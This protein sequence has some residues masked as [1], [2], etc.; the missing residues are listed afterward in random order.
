MER[1][2]KQGGRIHEFNGAQKV[3]VPQT[4][5]DHRCGSALESS[6]QEDVLIRPIGSALGMRVCPEVR[7]RLLHAGRTPAGI[8]SIWPL[9]RGGHSQI[10]HWLREA[11]ATCLS[12]RPSSLA[13]TP[14]LWEDMQ[15][16]T[17]GQ[18]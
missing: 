12:G 16:T 2:L 18:N 8:P 6:A 10:G 9:G 5:G 7:L 13:R 11:A 14:K 4:L 17:P 15:R 1:A 3:P